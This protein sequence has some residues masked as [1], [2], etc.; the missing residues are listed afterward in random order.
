MAI[1]AYKVKRIFEGVLMAAAGKPLTVSYLAQLLGK[2]NEFENKALKEI[3]KELSEDYRGRGITLEEVASGYRFQVSVDLSPWV[4]KLW[5]EKPARYSR[6]MMETLA[7]IAYRQPI[8][9]AEIEEVRGVAVSSNIVR[10]LI[11]HEWIKIAGHKDVPGR[12]AL[13]VTTNKFLDYF[14]L[15]SIKELPTLK[16]LA[17]LDKAAVQLEL[18]LNEN[19]ETNNQTESG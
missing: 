9:R 16:E 11:D 15:K 7:L 5:E 1:E 12:P 13:F 10:T 3:L 17:D 18:S 8:T 19:A 4:G 2:E 14:N 6:A